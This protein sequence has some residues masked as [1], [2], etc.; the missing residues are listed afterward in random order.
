MRKDAYPTQKPKKWE[1]LI[2]ILVITIQ[3][4]E[5]ISMSPEVGKW[6]GTHAAGWGVRWSSLSGGKTGNS[7]QNCTSV[8]PFQDVPGK[9]SAQ[10]GRWR[11]KKGSSTPVSTGLAAPR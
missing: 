10:Q 3:M 4:H 2:P 1:I 7:H 8:S 6:A 9:C 5:N 11:V